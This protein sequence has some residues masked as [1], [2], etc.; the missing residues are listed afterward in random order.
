MEREE[1]AERRRYE[2]EMRQKIET[3]KIK[4]REAEEKYDNKQRLININR[5]KLT[6]NCV[7]RQRCLKKK[8]E[9]MKWK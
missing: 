2:E 8:K 7:N 3:D 5:D 4:Q 6:R 9:N 1:R